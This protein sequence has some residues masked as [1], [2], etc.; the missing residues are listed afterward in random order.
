MDGVLSFFAV[1]FGDSHLFYRLNID[2]GDFGHQS[3]IKS[4]MDHILS[5]QRLAF[6]P[7]FIL[8]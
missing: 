7:A 1:G 3:R 2:A 6:L 5:N 4:S 8:F